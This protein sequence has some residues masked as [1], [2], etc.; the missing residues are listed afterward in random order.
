MSSSVYSWHQLRWYHDAQIGFLAA[1]AFQQLVQP[2]EAAERTALQL[3][4]PPSTRTSA[5]GPVVPIDENAVAAANARDSGAPAS[6]DG[7]P[8]AL[9]T[10]KVSD[11][12]TA[13][14][15]SNDAE[16][17]TL[18]LATSQINSGSESN[19]SGSARASPELDAGT[20]A[21]VTDNL[22]ES[23]PLPLQKLALIAKTCNTLAD[24]A[25]D[26]Q[27]SKAGAAGLRCDLD[28]IMA[29][30]RRPEVAS[31]LAVT[32]RPELPSRLLLLG[33][34]AVGKTSFCNLVTGG[35]RL[36]S[37][38]GRTTQSLTAFNANWTTQTGVAHHSDLID[39]PGVDDSAAMDLNTFMAIGKLSK[40]VNA[41]AL[42]LNGESI[43]LDSALLENLANY[44]SLCAQ[45]MQQSWICIITHWYM[46][47]DSVER[48]EADGKD[49]ETIMSTVVDGL[50]RHPFFQD[51]PLPA[52]YFFVDCSPRSFEAEQAT[53][54]ELDRLFDWVNA[55]PA[56]PLKMC[57]APRGHLRLSM[58][59]Q[60]AIIMPLLKCKCSLVP[61]N[62]EHEDPEA[63]AIPHI[64]LQIQSQRRHK[65]RVWKNK[66]LPPDA[67]INFALGDPES[68][69]ADDARTWSQFV[70]LIRHRYAELQRAAPGQLLHIIQSLQDLPRLV[71]RSI[72]RSAPDYHSDRD[73]ESGA[74][75]WTVFLGF[76]ES[77]DTAEV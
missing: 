58:L 29:T 43:V 12:E 66:R 4:G 20:D 52:E 3:L 18:Q 73:L 74:C 63:V 47:D 76:E 49:E 67:F 42:V 22:D 65:V 21:K 23:E 7:V 33:R 35:A 16:T 28:N 53:C 46:D 57:T 6:F 45:V 30:L 15:S 68:V 38:K 19:A 17:G 32:S 64:S 1:A 10:Y 36:T 44:Y 39:T 51:L 70:A 59:E 56:Q 34:S 37:A 25:E 31:N 54:S 55:Q 77:V 27:I 13:C 75:E 62:P 2:H 8:G 5:S 11:S 71:V 69:S 60:H 48:R 61:T 72:S 26:I 41:V 24:M 14:D 40:P 9:D 50:S